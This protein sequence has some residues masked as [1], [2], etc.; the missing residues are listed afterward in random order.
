MYTECSVWVMQ[1]PK[2]LPKGGK[3]PRSSPVCRLH[4]VL[5]SALLNDRS[6]NMKVLASI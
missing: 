3:E 4:C 5:V 1:M 2:S 6:A